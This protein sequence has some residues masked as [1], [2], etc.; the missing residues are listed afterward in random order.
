MIINSC[1][2]II[3]KYVHDTTRSGDSQMSNT[4][5]ESY[6]LWCNNYIRVIIDN[7]INIF[8]TYWTLNIH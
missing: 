4:R 3:K 7:N 1:I 5:I 2:I 6:K 8:N